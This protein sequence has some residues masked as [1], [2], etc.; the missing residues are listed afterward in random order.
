MIQVSPHPLT[1]SYHNKWRPFSVSCL[2]TVKGCLAISR[3]IWPTTFKVQLQLSLESQREYQLAVLFCLQSRLSAHFTSPI[4]ISVVGRSCTFL[5]H[6]CHFPTILNVCDFSKQPPTTTFT[7]LH[8]RA[9]AHR[10]VPGIPL[11][12]D[13]FNFNSKLTT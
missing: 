3:N 6:R 5:D 1:M 7:P 10:M 8:A 12:Y 4:R 2:Y 11:S 9:E 13:F